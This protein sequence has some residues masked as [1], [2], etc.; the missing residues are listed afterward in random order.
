MVNR[1]ESNIEVEYKYWAKMSKEEFQSRVEFALDS[2]S[3]PEYVV[4]CDDYYRVK[5]GD[6]F[7]RY[8]KGGN[9]RELTLK[10]KEKENV[11]RKE[12]NLSMSGND[13]SSVVE[14][15][16]LSGYT[17][18]FSV[19]KEAWIW[20]LDEAG[21][22]IS[23][24]TLSDGRSVI[25]IEASGCNNRETAEAIIN[26]WEKFLGLSSKEREKRSL[27]EIFLSEGASR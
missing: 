9:T 4:S 16:K 2:I 10:I 6:M 1:I 19:F 3:E 23:Y 25:E 24:Y 7:L 26:N 18:E 21:V 13:D 15:L 22:D 11:I 20:F 14:F 8:R 5:D 17:K 27:L 12:I